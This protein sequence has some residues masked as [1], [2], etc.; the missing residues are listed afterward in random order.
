MS[1][2]EE[3]YSVRVALR[4]KNL[5]DLARPVRQGALIVSEL[6]NEINRGAPLHNESNHGNKER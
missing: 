5:C 3:K 4:H 6:S 1:I 2:I